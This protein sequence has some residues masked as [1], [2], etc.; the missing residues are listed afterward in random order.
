MERSG[1]ELVRT[2]MTEEEY[3]D[4]EEKD[5][6]N[7]ENFDVGGCIRRVVDVID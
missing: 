2:A 4:E 1:M 5:D 3:T 6:C 7:H